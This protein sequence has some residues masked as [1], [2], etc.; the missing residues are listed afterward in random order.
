MPK[1]RPNYLRSR[2]N[3]RKATA[4]AN[5]SNTPTLLAAK[6][7]QSPLRQVVRYSCAISTRPL[8][9]IG[10]T[11]PTRKSLGRDMDLPA[12]KYSVQNTP[13]VPKYMMM[14]VS[15]SKPSNVCIRKEGGLIRQR[16]HTS[17]T[18]IAVKRYVR[19]KSVNVYFQGFGKVF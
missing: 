8:I 15:L 3:F 4:P 17:T 9:V 11:T 2:L 19:S 14:C 12:R 18:Q 5:A 16:Y 10:A 1:A 7:S 6:S 13:Q